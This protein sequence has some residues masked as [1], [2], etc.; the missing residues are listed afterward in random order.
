MSLKSSEF[1][2][3]LFGRNEAASFAPQKDASIRV[4]PRDLTFVQSSNNVYSG[5]KVQ[6]RM[7]LREV[8]ASEISKGMKFKKFRVASGKAQF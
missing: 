4:F 5:L 2:N 1:C 6:L 7:K 3:L 8:V